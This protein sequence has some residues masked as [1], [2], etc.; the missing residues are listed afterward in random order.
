MS[1]HRIA[2]MLD[3]LATALGPGL[4]AAAKRDLQ[5]IASLL[6]S[7]PDQRV[8]QLAKTVEAA[9][10]GDPTSAPALLRHVEQ[11]QAGTG[12]RAALDAHLKKAKTTALKQVYETVVGVKPGALKKA[13]LLQRI[14]SELGAGGS[15]EVAANGVSPAAEVDPAV[16]QEVRARF[17]DL[18][19]RVRE[20]EDTEVDRAL[21]SFREVPEAV[22][23]ALVEGMG[24]PAKRKDNVDYLKGA[25]QHMRRTFRQTDMI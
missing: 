17:E 9:V 8:T 4:S 23:A 20:L 16:L 22:L 3:G 1:T 25:L 19:G 15:T 13:D 7:L 24:Y 6:T 12:N 5:A 10:L 11:V 21:A 18:K 2:G 14:G